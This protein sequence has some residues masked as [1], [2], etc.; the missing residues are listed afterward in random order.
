MKALF[1]V[2]CNFRAVDWSGRM[3]VIVM[4]ELWSVLSC[5]WKCGVVFLLFELSGLG[6]SLLIMVKGLVQMV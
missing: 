1:I 4:S 2:I 6:P 5:V 3:S